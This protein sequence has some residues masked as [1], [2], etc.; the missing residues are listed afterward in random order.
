MKRARAV[1]ALLA[2]MALAPLT[3]W[4]HA[5]HGLTQGHEWFHALVPLLGAAVI[6]VLRAVVTRTMAQ[7]RIRRSSKK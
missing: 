1:V 6:V 4:A 3:A 2:V 5:G 7:A